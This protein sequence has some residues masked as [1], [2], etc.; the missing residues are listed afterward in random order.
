MSRT[1]A[2][3]VILLCLWGGSAFSF[4]DAEAPFQRGLA[5]LRKG[6]YNRAIAEFTTS[7]R[8][9]PKNAN[10][11]Y[12][13][14]LAYS[15]KKN[16][17]RATADY[18]EALRLNPKDADTYFNRAFAYKR[19][20]DY[21]RAIADYTQVI[22]LN[23]KDYTAYFN[24]A[25]A[26]DAKGD[27]DRAIADFTK[28]LQLKPGYFN[29]YLDRGVIYSKKKDYRRAIVDFNTAIKINPKNGE[30]WGRLG[31]CQY[32]IGQR[33]DALTNSRKALQLDGNLTWARLNVG[34][35]HAVQGD[36]KAARAAYR[37][38]LA[39]ATREEVETS[40]RNVQDALKQQ[41]GSAALKQAWEML[42]NSPPSDDRVTK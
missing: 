30:V 28:S 2:Q 35:I 41:P 10:A 17:D 26:H 9:N 36:W 38:A 42:R 15:K 21:D 39:K 5:A 7:I 27:D 8:L 11:Y 1:V 29:A 31:W 16:Y 3:T 32:C 34:L 4:D 37:A 18:T 25:F 14:G 22:R 13:R 24:R 40:L 19:K 12:N 33:A 6:N 23:P 20:G